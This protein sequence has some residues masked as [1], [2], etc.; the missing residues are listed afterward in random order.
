ME[1]EQTTHEPSRF[2][3]IMKQIWPTVN[4][5]INTVLYFIFNLVK[6]SVIYI[7]EQLKNF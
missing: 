1:I 2:M 6:S 5:T 4:R 3:I 7:I